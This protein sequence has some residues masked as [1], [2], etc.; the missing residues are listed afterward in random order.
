MTNF[1]TFTIRDNTHVVSGSKVYFDF[2]RKNMIST[3]FTL[4][5][6]NETNTASGWYGDACMCEDSIRV[7]DD[8][9]LSVGWGDGFAVRRILDNGS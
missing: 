4:R 1:K 5:D 2:L 8:I 7:H 3:V 6:D 9:I